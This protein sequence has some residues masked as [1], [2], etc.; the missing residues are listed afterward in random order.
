MSAPVWHSIWK[1]VIF[2]VSRICGLVLAHGT[3]APSTL[4]TEHWGDPVLETCLASAAPEWRWSR[5]GKP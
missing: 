4:G 2:A 5:A 3:E 1:N